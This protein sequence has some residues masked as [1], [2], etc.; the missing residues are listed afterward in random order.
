MFDW[1]MVGL[2]LMMVALL[3]LAL[4]APFLGHHDANGIWLGSAGRNLWEYGIGGRGF[5]PILNRAPI[6]P[7][8]PDYYVNH[9]PLV[10][11]ASALAQL[12]WG[13]HELALRM[14][15]IFATLLSLSAFFVFFRRLFGKA[16]GLLATALY[17][18]TPMIIYF[19]RMPNH[20][21]LVLAFL[22]LFLAEFMAW[23]YGRGSWWRLLAFA[24]GGVWTAW[25]MFFF[26]VICSGVGVLYL[27]GAVRRRAVLLPLIGGVFVASVILFFWVQYPATFEQ[28]TLAFRSRSFALSEY[29]SDAAATLTEFISTT[30]LHLLADVGLAVLLAA[31][32]GLFLVWRDANRLRRAIILALLLAGLAYIMVFR[33][34]SSIHDYYK[35]FMLPALAALA[36][37]PIVALA[38]LPASYKLLKL[39]A[40]AVFAGLWLSGA[41]FMIKWY[42]VGDGAGIRALGV[43]LRERTPERATVMTNIGFTPA[44]EYYASRYLIWSAPR[45]NSAA[46]PDLYYLYCAWND[47]TLNNGATPLFTTDGCEVTQITP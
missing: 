38:S 39:G 5:V 19:G 29:R 28:L 2:L 34:V 46:S 7:S 23:I 31:V 44:L 32:G 3:T 14:V 26:I 40:A 37:Y 41:V 8:I 4:D 16:R 27:R 24:A 10:V 6:P 9:P 35:I 22:G 15:S 13:D 36:T 47:P 45:T 18:L 21:P 25:A 11:Y 20:E 12:L 1:R 43:F 33:N 42:N 30:L 17:A